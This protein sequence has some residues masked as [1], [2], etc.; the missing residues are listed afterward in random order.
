MDRVKRN[1]GAR[2][3]NSE[4][5]S[6]TGGGDA[7]GLG[8]LQLPAD[9][10]TSIPRQ[11][12]KNVGTPQKRTSGGSRGGDDVGVVG[13]EG[14]GTTFLSRTKMRAKAFAGAP[15]KNMPGKKRPSRDRTLKAKTHRHPTK[16]PQAFASPGARP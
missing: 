11:Q 2:S 6:N 13:V 9:Y 5:T 10:Y 8:L 12:N 7:A 14:R 1:R 3:Q 4:S 16:M 15:T